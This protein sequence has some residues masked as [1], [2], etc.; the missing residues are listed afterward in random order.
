MS[1]QFATYA[2]QI[3]KERSVKD[4]MFK[5]PETSPL[6]SE[7]LSKFDGLDYYPPDEKYRLPG[8]LTQSEANE[9]VP[10]ATTSGRTVNVE[11]YGDVKFK[12][13]G[14]EYQLPVMK[15]K[16]LDEFA[17]VSGELFIAFREPTNG[18]ETH[19]DGR[20]LMVTAIPGTSAV[21]IDLNRAF[22]PKNAYSKT[23]ESLIPPDAAK[24]NSSSKSGQRKF[25][26]RR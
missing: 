8:T 20:Y 9:T 4:M 14:N 3:N 23:Y 17:G 25:E 18:T 22:N 19:P 5:E 12:F 26:D 7:S 24:L 13:E 11:K 6:T 1:E 15:T 21:E 2:D 16:D 10:L